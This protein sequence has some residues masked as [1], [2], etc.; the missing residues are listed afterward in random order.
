MP[1]TIFHDGFFRVALW[2]SL[3]LGGLGLLSR[4]IAWLTVRIGTDAQDVSFGQRLWSAVGGGVRA[5]FS[6]RLPGILAAFF[7]DV[8]LQRRLFFASKLRWAG[9]LMIL[10]GFTV[11]LV[12]HAMAALLSETLFDNYYA[13]LNP[14]LVLRNVFGAVTVLGVVLMAIGRRRDWASGRPARGRVDAVFAALLG[15][16]LLSGFAL[17]AQKIASPKAFY[18]MTDEFSLGND[19]DELAPLRWV[20]KL[21]YGVAFADLQGEP[22]PGVLAEGR[23]LNQDA[24]VDCHARPQGAF[25]SYP[26][27]RA[28][29]PVTATLDASNADRSLLWLHVLAC[30]LGIIVLPFTRFF[31]AVADPVSLVVRGAASAG[32]LSQAGRVSRRALAADACIRCGLCDARCSV[33]P[34]ARWLRNP[35]LLP[36]RKVQATRAVAVGGLDRMGDG[37]VD[38]LSDGAHL[39][40]DCGRCTDRCPVGLDLE[41]LW[42]AGRADLAQR[43]LPAPAAW[44]RERPAYAWAESMDTELGRVL[45]AG[46]LS[47]DRRT[48]SAC[49]Q[50]QTC[51]NVCPVVAYG[52]DDTDR[53]DLTPQ[54]VMNLLR[55][56]M[57]DL[58]LGSRMVWDCATCYQCQENCPEGIRVTDV[59]LELRGAAW[60]QL[61]PLRDRRQP[62]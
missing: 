20:W 30:L 24:C 5:L 62:E 52:G 16:V 38:R 46:P 35:E 21:D 29:G 34:L 15:V 8:L 4:V 22:D 39:C 10:I 17:E 47:S 3:A 33:A 13:T 25:V 6:R 51:T 60:R 56:G 53:V 43:G 12:M 61:G 31:H 11:L 37:D 27:A 50:C 44:V 54:K 2:V 55:L 7:L 41:D 32:P 58:A 28:L 18:R 45:T 14:F 59:M 9:H 40:T 23:E 1:E 57:V 26:L 49:V 19:P 42:E 48:F 36:S